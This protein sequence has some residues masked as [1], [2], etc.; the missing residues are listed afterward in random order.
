M[1]VDK[2]K[3][4]KY[5]MSE[6]DDWEKMGQLSIDTRWGSRHAFIEVIETVESGQLDTHEPDNG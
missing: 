4:I 5:L 6:I 3:L 2:D 1:A